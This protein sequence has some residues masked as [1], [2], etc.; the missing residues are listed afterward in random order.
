M[1][2]VITRVFNCGIVPVIKLDNAEDALPLS[3]A[4][5]AGGINVA[6]ITFRTG[7]ASDA[8]K[9]ISAGNPKML[10]GAGTVSNIE[11]AERAI[12]AGAQFIVSPGFNGKVVEYCLDKKVAVI[13]GISSPTDIETAL[14]YGLEYLKF[15]PAEA[16][17][18][19]KALKAMSAPYGMIKFMPTGGIDASNL[20]EYLRF[21]KVIACGGSWMCGEALVKEKKFDEITR[22]SKEAVALM[23]GFKFA[24]MAINPGAESV[25]NL[26]DTFTNVFGF[27][28]RDTS[29]SI[30]ATDFIELM[31]ADGM[32][33]KGHIGIS[34]HNA[35]RAL[36]YF[37]ERGIAVD[38]DSIVLTKGVPTFAYL[39]DS[40]GGFAVHIIQK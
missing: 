29:K 11:T 10:V 13:P 15:F 12:A 31:N 39:K 37:E 21:E 3:S 38:Q 22:L 27:P 9:A 8:I 26:A 35:A 32:G 4:L 17:G 5:S 23:H 28:Q 14:G 25:N 30:F 19:L 16:S 7:A 6:E 40:I 2:N 36:A 24:H 18:G 1:S 34:T 33:E 20:V